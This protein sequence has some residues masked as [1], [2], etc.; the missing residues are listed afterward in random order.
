MECTYK[1]LTIRNATVDDAA[2]LADWWNDVCGEYGVTLYIGIG[3][4]R[5]AESG[6]Y[7]S[8]DEIASQ[9]AYANGKENC[10]GVV[11]FSFRSLRKNYADVQA[12]VKV[13]YED[14]AGG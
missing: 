9:V 2:I 6:A 4:Y 11:F 13:A 5:G 1:N 14:F 7:S 8:P 3:A 10:K 12:S